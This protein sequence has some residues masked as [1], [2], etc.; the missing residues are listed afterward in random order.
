MKD[1]RIPLF[2]FI[3]TLQAATKEN[4]IAWKINCRE[5]NFP[6]KIASNDASY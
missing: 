3:A 1:K 2:Q 6:N 5:Q 4:P